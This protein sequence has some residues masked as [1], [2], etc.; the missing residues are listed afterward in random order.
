MKTTRL[1]KYPTASFRELL[2]L[3]VPL[4][5]SFVSSYLILLADRFFLSRYSLSAFEACAAASGLYFFFQMM[6]LRFVSTVQAFVGEAVGKGCYRDASAYTWQ[7]LWFSFFSPFF[8]IPIGLTV[9][10][11]FFGGTPIEKEALVYFNYMICGNFLFSVEGT[12]SGFFS[13]IGQTRKV[14]VVQFISQ[15]SNLILSPLLIFGAM[16]IIPSI[17]IHGAAIGTLVAKMISCLLLFCSFLFHPNLN[18][19]QTKKGAFCWK[20]LRDCL[21]SAFP[22][23]VGQG[24]SILTW[25]FAARILIQKGGIDL[26]SCTFGSTVHLALL[27]DGLGLAFLTVSSYLIGSKQWNYFPKLLRSTFIFICL[28]TIILT[29]PFFIFREGLIRS[30]CPNITQLTELESLRTTSAFIWL[31]LVCNS[32]FVISFMLLTALKDL[33]FYMIFHSLYTPLIIPI[34]LYMS[35]Q[36]IWSPSLFWLIT[37]LQPLSIAVI[38]FPRALYRLRRLKQLH[39]GQ[40]PPS[41][42]LSINTE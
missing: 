9:G 7:M 14:F 40:M 11:Y 8:L 26:L 3:S 19:Y 35:Q 6:T 16:G 17:G 33:C 39:V 31:S 34:T 23:A 1:S 22:R 29:L 2:S 24:V 30:L 13:G 18:G 36:N 10:K 38:Y 27:N 4:I 28:N 42:H 5:L 32:L 41:P 12:L 20:K 25:N 37:G 21:K 15:I